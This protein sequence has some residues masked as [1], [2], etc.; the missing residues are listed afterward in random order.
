MIGAV[1]AVLRWLL[2]AQEPHA[3]GL[4]AVQLSHGFTFAMTLVGTMGLLVR[5]VPAHMT[6]R[7]QGYYAA[8]S[9]IIGSAASMVSGPVYAQYGH[10]VYYLMAL[11]AALGGVLMW[12]VRRKVALQP[13]SAVSGG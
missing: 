11:M 1:A 5:Y 3:I 8:S 4:A 2:T 7:G 9:G 13:H 12:L 6:A 10:G